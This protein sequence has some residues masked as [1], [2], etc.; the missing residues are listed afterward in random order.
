MSPLSLEPWQRKTSYDLVGIWL[1]VEDGPAGDD[2]VASICMFW[3]TAEEGVAELAELALAVSSGRGRLAARPGSAGC[4]A[5]RLTEPCCT[6]ACAG[7]GGSPVSPGAESMGTVRKVCGVCVACDGE[8]DRRRLGD[9]WISGECRG[10][11]R[12]RRYDYFNES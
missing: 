9:S 8:G 5:R 11:G 12:G 3:G 2:D 1:V 4:P 6:G 10:K 7:R